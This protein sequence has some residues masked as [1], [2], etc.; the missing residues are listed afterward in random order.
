MNHVSLSALL[1][2]NLIYKE[3][4]RSTHSDQHTTFA[5]NVSN[6]IV[7]NLN[8]AIIFAVKKN[9]QQAWIYVN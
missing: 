6:S 7:Y 3:N 2:V 5:E 9:I 4:C 1:N 8:M